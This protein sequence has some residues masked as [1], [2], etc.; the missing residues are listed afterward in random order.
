MWNPLFFLSRFD[1]AWNVI[2]EKLYNLYENKISK[3]IKT[4]FIKIKWRCLHAN[5]ITPQKQKTIYF[6]KV[7]MWIENK[8][9]TSSKNLWFT[10]INL[11][12][13]KR[14]S[15][16]W[17][18]SKQ[19]LLKIVYLLLFFNLQLSFR[20]CDDYWNMTEWLKKQRWLYKTQI[21][22]I[23]SKL[24]CESE[25]L[26]NENSTLMNMVLLF[27][28]CDSGSYGSFIWKWWNNVVTSCCFCL[29]K[30]F[31]IL[32]HFDFKIFFFLSIAFSPSA[33]AD[34]WLVSNRCMR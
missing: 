22:G 14:W 17:I 16:C 24:F 27:F 29:L 3:K 8:M 31:F 34:P 9:I 4:M 19:C 13:W 5:L 25:T 11:F 21:R 12:C 26:M 32:E 23:C 30:R 1:D 2:F 33:G 28:F 7:V 15:G 6:V 18:I 10:I 20:F